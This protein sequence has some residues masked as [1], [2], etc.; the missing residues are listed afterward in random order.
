MKPVGDVLPGVA[1]ARDAIPALVD[2]GWAACYTEEYRAIP[3][4][5]AQ[6][7]RQVVA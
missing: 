3:G 6:A 2:A 7:I 5:H 4:I 1:D